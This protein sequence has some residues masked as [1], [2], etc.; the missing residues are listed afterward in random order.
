M[1]VRRGKRNL[2][3]LSLLVLLVLLGWVR[4]KAQDVTEI[5]AKSVEANNRD[6]D[7]DP[8]F[9]Y[10]E[11]DRDEHG[12]RTY[13]VTTILGTPYQRLVEINGKKLSPAQESEQQQK[14][15]NTVS[16]R[17]A[18]SPQQRSE[19]IAKFD[20]ERRRDHSML[21]QLTKAFNFTLE[22]QQKLGTHSVYVLKATP[23]KGYQPSN[24][25][26][27]V[28]PGMEGKLWIDKSTFQWVKVEAHVVHPVSIEGF[29][30]EVEPGTR[31]ELEKMPVENNIWLTKHFA[32]T[33]SA[34][35]LFLLHHHSQ[36]DDSYFNYH[37]RQ[38]SSAE[39]ASRAGAQG[40]SGQ[41]H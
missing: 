2:R 32:M 34:K 37:R 21:S 18:E 1:R 5:I 15:D 31:F 11:R 25:D 19:R 26:T 40:A 33:A 20:A 13:V 16:Q 29:L 8:Q 24:R 6:W 3:T 27:E 39:S 22:G 14:F 38:A 36:E 10:S 28:L 9:D 12:T 35:V 17:R 41:P 30:A 4:A 23:R 7:A